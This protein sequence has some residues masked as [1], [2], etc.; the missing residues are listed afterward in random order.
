MKQSLPLY[1]LLLLIVFTSCSKKNAVI[2][3]TYF[4]GEIVNPHDNFVLLYKD[5]KL[6]DTIP[7]A[8]N[9]TF[10][11]QFKNFEKGLYIFKHDEFQ[12]IYIEPQD[13]LF[14][15]LNTVDFD[16]T[17]TFSGKGATKN[18]FLIHNFLSNETYAQNFGD[19]SNMPPVQFQKKMD[20]ALMQSHI[21][22]D[23][24]LQKYQFSEDFIT[25][26]KTLI[27]Y[28]FYALKE[29]Y[30]IFNHKKKDFTLPENYYDYRKNINFNATNLITFYPYFN[31]LNLFINNVA[32]TTNTCTSPY[33]TYTAKLKVID[34]IIKDS[35]I[36]HDLLQ[37]NGY[38]YF[39]K[40]DNTQ[41]RLAFLKTFKSCTNN[42]QLINQISTL[43]KSVM[44]LSKG[45]TFPNLELND[46]NHQKVYIKDVV[47]TPT[48]IYFW[49]QKQPRHLRSVHKKTAAYSQN[50]SY[51]FIG[52]CIDDDASNWEKI[53]T[54]LNYAN[55]YKIANSKDI[56]QKLLLNSIHK[57]F[58]LNKDNVILS[59][60]LNLY[61]PN[62]I[63]KLKKL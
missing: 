35:I 2:N 39:Y 36:K 25:I 9:N 27:D 41:N 29:K 61:D 4:G 13:S 57:V 7:L 62:F 18:N 28:N 33:K 47:K 56:A 59:S 37:K 45:T 53:M 23:K 24:Y 22:L 5:N 46:A 21:L 44:Q 58:V 12:Y 43:A 50:S 30:V 26:A 11:Y 48:V 51:Q 10:T 60:D 20:S 16:E 40:N 38:S 54:N 8:K 6:I 42:K 63:K 49:T 15:R 1:I 52:I 19:Y 55:D 34:S 3:P 31:Y 17:L 14:L 32:R